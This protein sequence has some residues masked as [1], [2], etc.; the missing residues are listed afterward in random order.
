M[1]IQLHEVELMPTTTFHHRLQHHLNSA[2][3][4]CKL[5]CIVPES[6]ARKLSRAW[7]ILVHPLIY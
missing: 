3:I 2:H 4:Y 6:I 7:E 5:C 1:L